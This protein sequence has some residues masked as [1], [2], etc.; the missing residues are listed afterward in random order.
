MKR[1]PNSFYIFEQKKSQ[2]NFNTSRLIKETIA[3]FFLYRLA[4]QS[5]NQSAEEKIFIQLA[6]EQQTIENLD[7]PS[8]VKLAIEEKL[9]DNLLN[10]PAS[11]EIIEAIQ[12]YDTIDNLSE[13]QNEMEIYSEKLNV[14]ESLNQ[15]NESLDQLK[16]D[17]HKDVLDA[18]I[19][20]YHPDD[21]EEVQNRTDEVLEKLE[22]EQ[23]FVQDL[24]S[25]QVMGEEHEQEVQTNLEYNALEGWVLKCF[26]YTRV[27]CFLL[28]FL[29]RLES[30]Q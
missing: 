12:G 5:V 24:Q 27:F 11:Q 28:R 4:S 7:I 29:R 15:S 13:L 30:K 25:V 21:N 16:S 23:E 20:I 10:N 22:L 6:E 3:N 2:S 8:E 19:E 9:E 18:V 17:I 14:I 1:N 26:S